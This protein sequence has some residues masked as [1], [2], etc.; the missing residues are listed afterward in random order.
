MYTGVSLL[1]SSLS[2][3]LSSV[4]SAAV[5]SSVVGSTGSYSPGFI[6]PS[7]REPVSDSVS[8][9]ASASLVSLVD[10]IHLFKSLYLLL[11]HSVMPILFANLWQMAN[12]EY[13]Y[14][15]WNE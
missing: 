2:S 6:S 9:S 11:R 12:V 10:C 5:C 15:V 13:Q 1:G 14:H 4:I 3:S 7:G 8:T